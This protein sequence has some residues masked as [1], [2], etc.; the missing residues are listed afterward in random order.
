MRKRNP[1]SEGFTL[2]ELLIVI[3][4]LGILAS[5]VVISV[6]SLTDNAKNS[7]CKTE[8]DTVKTAIESYR[9][10]H[11]AVAPTPAGAPN[12]GPEMAGGYT[13]TLFDDGLLASATVKYYDGAPEAT[14]TMHWTISNGGV[15][16]TDACSG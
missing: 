10:Q 2:V 6:G 5:I 13:K 9:A 12:D 3:V 1:R 16:L 4:I 15:T 14:A 11:R 7:A 8:A